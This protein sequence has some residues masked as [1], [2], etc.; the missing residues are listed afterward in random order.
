[1]EWPGA[2]PNESHLPRVTHEGEVCCSAKTR[3]AVMCAQRPACFYRWPLDRR[4]HCSP[5]AFFV[6]LEEVSNHGGQPWPRS[7][8]Y[9][10]AGMQRQIER[11]VFWV[12]V[13][14]VGVLPWGPAAGQYFGIV[15]WLILFLVLI[16]CW[17]FSY[18]S[19]IQ[20]MM[21]DNLISV[22]I[23]NPAFVSAEGLWVIK[24]LWFRKQLFDYFWKICFFISRWEVDEKFE[25]PV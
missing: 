21:S 15:S 10:L 8:W 14:P 25:A 3:T 20:K 13:Q 17:P 1:M 7:L 11:L 22:S 6:V 12:R 16:L 9:R 18:E 19:V 5:S 24:D 4:Q 2:E 23:F